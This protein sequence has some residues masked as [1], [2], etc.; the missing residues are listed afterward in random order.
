M[1][2]RIPFEMR[3]ASTRANEKPIVFTNIADRAT[4]EAFNIQVRQFI[5]FLERESRL[6]FTVRPLPFQSHGYDGQPSGDRDKPGAESAAKSDLG[7]LCPVKCPGRNLPA[8]RPVP[9]DILVAIKT[10]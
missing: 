6:I 7:P 2:T 8:L 5:N 9:S 4:D 3:R 1:P 10:V